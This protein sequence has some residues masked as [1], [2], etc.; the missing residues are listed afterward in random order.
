MTYFLHLIFGFAIGFVGVIPPGLLNLTA[1][2]I[3]VKNGQRAAILFAAGASSV[4]IAQ[5]YIGVF[6]SKL[7]SLNPDILLDVR[8]I[9]HHHLFW[10]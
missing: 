7:L 1:A 10:S 5:V 2:K 9:C 6:F 8:A 3:S 4:V